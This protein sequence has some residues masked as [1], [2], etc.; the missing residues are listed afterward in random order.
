MAS[1]HNGLRP[2]F[3]VTPL[4]PMR[5]CCIHHSVDYFTCTL[6]LPLGVSGTLPNKK[7][8]T[9]LSGISFQTYVC[10]WLSVVT[11][12]LIINLN[13]NHSNTLGLCS[14][15]ITSRV[16]NQIK[17]RQS[18]VR[19]HFDGFECAVCPYILHVFHSVTICEWKNF[20]SVWVALLTQRNPLQLVSD[21]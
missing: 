2:N 1:H 15:F 6:M 3:Q 10:E 21:F 9:N 14:S 7:P 19:G 17:L 13:S 12:C 16:T 18:H 8:Q 5:L 20:T 11:N 4:W